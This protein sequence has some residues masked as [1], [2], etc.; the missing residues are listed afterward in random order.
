MDT[1]VSAQ[2]YKRVWTGRANAFLPG[3]A[4]GPCAGK[5]PISRVYNVGRVNPRSIAYVII[6]VSRMFVVYAAY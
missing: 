5:Q 3:V 2:C 1:N 4:A 6:L